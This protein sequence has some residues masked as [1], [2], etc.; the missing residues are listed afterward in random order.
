[1]KFIPQTEASECGLACL[2][3]VSCHYGYRTD[4]ATLRRQ[5]SVSLKG[6]TLEHLLRH[7]GALGFA[8]RPLRL[9]IDDLDKLTCPCILHWNMDHFVVLKKVR[10]TLRGKLELVIL[11]PAVGERHL[12]EDAVSRSFTGVALELTP[13]PTF[14]KRAPPKSVSMDDMIGKV[15]GLRR[16]VTQVLAFAIGLEL[17]SLVTPLFSQ[18]ILDDVV[19]GG[20]AELLHALAIGFGLL[21]FTQSALSL[22]R[23]WFLMCWG[24]E[25]SLQWTTRVFA[26]LL[27][28]P[29][30]FFEKRHL[31][32]VISRFGSLATIQR[33]MTSVLV[34]SALDG[35]LALLALFMMLRYSGVLTVVV[36]VSV[37]CYSLL[38][39][40][41]YRPLRAA[42][43]ETLLM[44][45]KEESHFLETLRAI[46]PLKLFGRESERMARWMNIRQDATNHDLKTQKIDVLFR[47]C[48]SAISNIQNLLLF[49]LG[50]EL[51]IQRELS[52]GMLT[53]FS[54]Y[55]GTFTT[56]VFNLIDVFV[57]VRMLAVHGERLAD[58][59]L[60][61]PEEEV[62]MPADLS[63]IKPNITLRNIRFRYS[64]GEPWIIDQVDLHIPA[65]QSIALV[66]PSGCGKT[67]LCKIILGLLPPTE[68]EVL[69]DNIP[70]R[71]LGLKAYRQLVGTVMQDDDLL[72]G[73]LMD[74][75]SFYDVRSDHEAVA[76]CAAMASIHDDIIA[77]P[78][79]YH[80]MV[81]DMGSI[82]SG[83]QKQRVLLARALYK[84]PKILA[85]D[86]ATSHLD[87]DNERKVNDA[88]SRLDLTRVMIAHRPETIRAAERVVL[89]QNG[90]IV[91]QRSSAFPR[92]A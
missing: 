55:A 62:P 27:R 29:P 20:D 70:I 34:E 17:L 3:M 84:N 1:M 39:W 71:Q 59:V 44:R 49:Y 60:E 47:A 91:E 61:A 64:D 8:S 73:S 4:L 11:D 5:F 69:I 12:N 7:A 6:M 26:H 76:R 79:G 85:M 48:N 30:A 42:T 80:S 9:E 68:G 72:A 50:A 57:N 35:V 19:V 24:V 2:A 53:A 41:F 88:L 90:K 16:A 18:F 33:T 87:V 21:I 74:N 92:I 14:E 75:I 38:R 58:I 89:I 10:R 83:G 82:L 43:Q 54:I 15:V 63:R 46:T 45:A 23:S 32:D 67:T 37:L 78:M 86:E 13:T 28:L 81:G 66:G 51:I 52:V 25:L 40:T 31:G 65:G 77:M 56:R 22:A 36:T